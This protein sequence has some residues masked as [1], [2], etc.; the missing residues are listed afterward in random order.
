MK[1]PKTW[2]I[3][4]NILMV[5]AFSLVHAQTVTDSIFHD[6]ILRVD[7]NFYRFSDLHAH[8]HEANLIPFYYRHENELAELR[9]MPQSA[10]NMDMI[11]VKASPDIS[12]LW[13]EKET[14][15]V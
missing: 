10:V 12:V 11:G 7:T 13:F 2:Y 14:E 3:L 8:H 6:I 1:S 5:N 9:L 4:L 15:P